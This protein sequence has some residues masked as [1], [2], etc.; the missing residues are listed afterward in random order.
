MKTDILKRVVPVLQTTQN[1][2]QPIFMSEVFQFEVFDKIYVM[3]S[4]GDL[5]WKYNAASWFGVL[6]V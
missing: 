4:A 3:T 5:V 1:M 6:Q 2:Y